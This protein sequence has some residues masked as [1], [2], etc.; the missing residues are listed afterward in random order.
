MIKNLINFGFVM[1]C[2]SMVHSLI[3]LPPNV[4]F[5]MGLGKS[6]KFNSQSCS[7]KQRNKRKVVNIVSNQNCTQT[8]HGLTIIQKS[9]HDP[10]LGG[11]ITLP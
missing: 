7:I 11:V 6:F 8:N 1:E 3:D 5:E 9:C 4:N 10:N 2:K